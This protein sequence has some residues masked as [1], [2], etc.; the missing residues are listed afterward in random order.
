MFTMNFNKSVTARSSRPFGKNRQWR[1]P[2][3]E[4]IAF[5]RIYATDPDDLDDKIDMVPGRI[6]SR[7]VRYRKGSSGL[8]ADVRFMMI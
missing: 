2:C 3:D 7:K 1:R 6:V 5:L 8:V 4:A